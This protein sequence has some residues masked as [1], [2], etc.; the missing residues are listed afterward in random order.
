MAQGFGKRILHK[1]QEILSIHRW[2][3]Y[4]FPLL[5]FMLVG[6][7]E[8]TDPGSPMYRFYPWIYGVKLLAT[9]AALR[10][11][12]PVYKSMMRPIGWHG[13]AIG[14]VGAALWIGMCHL[15]LERTYLVPLIE[16][17]GLDQFLG[18]Q[19]RSAYNPFIQLSG[20]PFGIALYLVIR[21]I[22]LALIVPIVEEYFLRGFLMRFV[23]ADKWWKYPIGSVTMNS[24]IAGTLVPMLMHPSELIAA[25]I[26]FSLITL[27]YVHSKN[28]W[29]C[30]AAHCTTNLLIGIYVVLFGA[31]QLV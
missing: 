24:V 3:A 7:F 22:G 25:A 30:I 6:G 31:W 16:R 23:A 1:W 11:V 5:V 21:G 8:P 14:I 10:V 2:V 13:I 27:L 9:M 28:L 4:V 29:E 19:T 12:W 18:F 26:W 20:Y 15:E 17:L